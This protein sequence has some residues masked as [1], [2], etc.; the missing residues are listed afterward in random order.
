MPEVFDT[1][2]VV[3]ITGITEFTLRAWEARY[4]APMP[5]RTAKGRRV[6]TR[7]DVS[8][9]RALLDLTVRGY[10]IGEI[11]H[12][13][14]SKLRSLLA[15]EV[16]AKVHEQAASPLNPLVEKILVFLQNL[17]FEA[18]SRSMNHF[19]K[20]NS[21]KDFIFEVTL[22]LL[23]RLGKEVSEG[24]ISIVQEHVLCSLLKENL[25]SIRFAL[26][27]RGDARCFV[28]ATPE[29]DFHELGA[30]I[31]A[32]L[33]SIDGAKVIYLGP[34]VPK[35]NLCE[36]SI[37]FRASHVLLATTAA[38][39]DGAKDDTLS[40][41]NFLD[42]NLPDRVSLWLGGR[43][44]QDISI[45]LKRSHQVFK[46]VNELQLAIERNGFRSGQE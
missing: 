3:D 31:G 28:V 22:P 18:I 24:R 6:Y 9:V 15:H 30:L 2:Q 26:K 4:G 41:I 39:V 32:T 46:T 14:M 45:R 40:L 8:K 37:Q 1:R 27:V 10:R 36:A 12:L 33:L 38:K 21:P 29:G 43:N 42:R 35:A 16:V 5:A 11:A 44:V 20:S 17:D 19:R 25:F 13:S 34:H 23:E 7:R